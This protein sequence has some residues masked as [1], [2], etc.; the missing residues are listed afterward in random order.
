[1][2]LSSRGEGV[3]LILNILQCMLRGGEWFPLVDIITRILKNLYKVIIV[4]T[5]IP[6][7]SSPLMSL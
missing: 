5:N 7:R 6:S 2:M 3:L 1:M 4:S